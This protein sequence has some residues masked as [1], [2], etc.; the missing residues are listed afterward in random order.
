MLPVDGYAVVTPPSR[1]AATSGDSSLLAAYDYDLPESRIAQQPVEPRSAAKLLVDIGRRGDPDLARTVADLPS[2]LAPGDI[3]VVNE[4]KVLPARLRLHKQTGGE[5]EVLLLEPV[6]APQER[7]WQALVRPARRLPPGTVLVSVAG[8]PVVEVGEPHPSGDGRR[9]VELLAD[10]ADHGV[11]PL[12]PYIHEQLDDPDRYQTVYA[13]NPGSVAAPTA[14]LHLTTEVLDALR[15][16]GIDVHTVDLAVGLDTFRPIAVDVIDAHEMH[17][18]RY[19][20]P[21][22]TFEACQRATGR[23]VAVGTT[24]VRALE[25]AAARNELAGRTDLFIRPGFR[26]QVV[27]VLLTNFH[28]PKSSLLVLLAAF[29]GTDRWRRLYDLALAD[30][31]RFLSFGDAMLVSRST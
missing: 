23:V 7:R 20:V 3:V 18:E 6:G 2:L 13:R 31:F 26:F 27:D 17:T 16:K 8:T 11:V 30:D 25:S 4:T 1:F 19:S 21:E 5:A 29:A 10:P 14:G 22:A 12:P 15:D 24:T 9:F 28:M